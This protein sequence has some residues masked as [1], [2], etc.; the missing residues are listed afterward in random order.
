MKRTRILAFAAAMAACVIGSMPLVFCKGREARTC[1][2]A[3]YVPDALYD[4]A[5]GNA[6]KSHN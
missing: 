5:K 3:P 4:R 2:L 1:L 6:S